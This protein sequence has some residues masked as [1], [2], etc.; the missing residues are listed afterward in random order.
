MLN[1][2]RI[3]LNELRYSFRKKNENNHIQWVKKVGEKIERGPIRFSFDKV[4][5]YNLW[6]DY[7]YKLTPEE[8]EFFDQEQPFWADFFKSRK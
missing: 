5:I 2:V 8:K 1:R 4:K 3:M 6:T 7:L